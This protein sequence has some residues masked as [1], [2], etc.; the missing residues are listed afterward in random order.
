MNSREG[1]TNLE[2]WISLFCILEILGVVQFVIMT[3]IAMVFYA[4]GSKPDPAARG[5]DFFSNF[6]SD[7]ERVTSYDGQDNLMSFTIFTLSL[8]IVAAGNVFFFI[9]LPMAFSNHR[10]SHRLMVIRQQGFGIHEQ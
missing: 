9:A 4:G 7:L 1:K 5:Y 8:C 10:G 2:R 3:S 6:F